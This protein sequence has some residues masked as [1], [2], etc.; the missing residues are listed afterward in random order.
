MRC[1]VYGVVD[2]PA[3]VSTVAGG[4][5]GISGAYADGFGSNAGFNYPYGVAVDA[6]GNV[7]VADSGNR[8]IRKVAASGGT[9]IGRV[10]LH[11][12]AECGQ[13]FRTFSVQGPLFCPP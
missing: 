8:R 7:F 2:E 11:A 12:R 10:T 1:V 4:V 6:I 5:N 13:S 3:V 9:R